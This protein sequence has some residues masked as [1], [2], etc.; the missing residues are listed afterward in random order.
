MVKYQTGLKVSSF[1]P[2][3]IGLINGFFRKGNQSSDADPIE[4]ADNPTSKV[5]PMF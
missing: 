4:V 1:S 3:K 5:V 2:S